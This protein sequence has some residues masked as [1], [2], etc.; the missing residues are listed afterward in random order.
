MQAIYPYTNPLDKRINVTSLLNQHPEL[1]IEQ[2]EYNINVT[3]NYGKNLDPDQVFKYYMEHEGNNKAAHLYF[4]VPLCSYVC[5]FCNYVK[6]LIPSN[7][8]QEDY[9]NRWTNALISESQR[10]LDHVKWLSKAKIESFFIGG[11]TAAI[12][13][14][15]HLNNLL[16]HVRGN[17]Q[18][19]DD[20][21]LTLEGNP[22]NFFN[23]AAVF[24]AINV[25]FNRFSIG[26]QSLQEE[27]NK[28]T[29]RGHSPEMSLQAIENLLKTGCPFNVDMMFGLP[30]QTP[31]KAASDIQTLVSLKVP[32]I[33]I[34]RFRNADRQKMG[35][36]NRSFW[37]TPQVRDR[38]HREGLFPTLSQTYAM[39]E[40][41]VHVL[42]ENGY[43]PSPCGWWSAPNTYS[44]TN[45]PQVSRNKWQY[46]D[47]MIA[48]G[49]GA[50][51]WITG[52]KSEVIQTHNITDI[53]SYLKH[54]ENTST[55]P[56]A[57]G[58]FIKG[59]QAIGVAL[60][61][62]FKANQ[63]IEIK[64]FRD[65]FGVDLLKEKPF[66]D[67]FRTLLS[68]GLLEIIQDGSALQPT[69]KGEALHEEI[70]SVYLHGKIGAFSASTCGKF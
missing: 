2:E 57:Y 60:G 25:G 53:A 67:V 31:K 28:F 1:Q 56:L 24:D 69:L 7:I 41:I 19:T 62:A 66:C 17:Y 68:K 51:G 52:G 33:T 48:F 15:K 54:I 59:F 3:A 46:H 9:L 12:L 32:T 42:L 16:N 44:P 13:K 64:R 21:E 47:T 49:P 34:Y 5:H 30:F 55:A 23:I 37:N 18:L 36:G 14:A 61:F 20:C 65:Q 63:P 39:R 4:H 8:D 27:V 35:I 58:R 26:V 50:Y 70:I 43:R 45:I 11:G 40:E 22:D 10:Y 29:N 38:L 6:Q